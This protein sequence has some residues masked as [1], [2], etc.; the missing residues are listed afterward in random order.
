MVTAC[1]SRPVPAS[2]SGFSDEQYVAQGAEMVPDPDTVFAG[3][4]T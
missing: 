3:S 4:R 1:S 2:A